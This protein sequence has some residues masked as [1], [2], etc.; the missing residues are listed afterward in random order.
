MFAV[1]YR[2]RAFFLRPNWNVEG[3]LDSLG[4]PY[5]ATRAEVA[6]KSMRR[7]DAIKRLYAE[8]GLSPDYERA[9]GPGSG[10]ADTMDSHRLAW[11]AAT[12]GKGEECWAELSRRYFEGKPGPIVL[13]NH[14][15]LLEVAEVVGLD[16]AAAAR[17][18][19]SGEFKEEVKADMREMQQ[20]GIE[21][22]PVMIFDVLS[23]GRGDPLRGALPSVRHDGSG[24]VAD[25][26]AI[27]EGL[28]HATV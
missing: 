4:L 28:H 25:Y 9:H 13:G 10:F 11:Y 5:D 1:E 6:A 15:Q 19:E 17:V 26:V 16:V 2:R 8:A 7:H 27:L 3:Y 23:N 20:L 22:I 12:V 14:R 18:L 21:G 24:K